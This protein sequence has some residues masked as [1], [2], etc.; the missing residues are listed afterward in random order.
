[1]DE[2]LECIRMNLY[3]SIADRLPI[4]C[5]KGKRKC[6]KQIP[7]E[8]C[9]RLGLS[10]ERETVRLRRSIRRSHDEIAYLEA[11]KRM[12]QNSD[13]TDDVSQS[14]T[15]RIHSLRSGRTDLAPDTGVWDPSP[16]S[17]SNIPRLVAGAESTSPQEPSSYQGNLTVTSLEHM[18]W[19]RNYGGCFPH[20]RCSCQYRRRYIG[21]ASLARM[22]DTERLANVSAALPEP[23]VAKTLV[24]FHLE[25]IAWHHNAIHCPGFRRQCDRFWDTGEYD[26]PQWLSLYS[27]I[28]A[29]S[30]MCLQNSWKY[31]EA[32]S[33]DLSQYSPLSSFQA[34]V[35]ILYCTNF[36]GDI[37]LY[38]VQAIVVSTEVAHNLGLSQLNATLFSAAIRISECLGLH[39]ISDDG[40]EDSNLSPEDVEDAMEKEIGRRIWLQ[41]IIQDHFAIPFTDSYGI[42]PSRYSTSIPRNSDNSSLVAAPKSTPTT[43]TY[44]RVLGEIA[45]LMPELVDGM[46]SLRDPRAPQEQYAHVL[47]MDAKMRQTVRDIPGFLLQQN[48]NLEREYPWLSCARHSL[49]ITAAEKVNVFFLL[50]V[51]SIVSDHSDHNDTS[52]LHTT[53]FSMLYLPSYETNL[54]GSSDHDSSRA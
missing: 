23:E 10:C 37:T 40:P 44:N 6:N 9:T 32:Y 17:A 42:H 15:A 16:A 41:M 47:K 18:A 39:K 8:R 49:A 2:N 22:T 13:N 1:M 4:E 34:M 3:E 29:T 25:N 48:P 19:G 11:L 30:L 53:V 33:V 20:V 28:L 26:H 46:G 31:R 43:S 51:D 50:Q 24:S 12:C 14:I 35:D 38:S 21:P 52:T 36:L 5:T 7:C 54:H 27:A 45:L